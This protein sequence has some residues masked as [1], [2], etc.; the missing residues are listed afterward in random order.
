MAPTA[1]SI[2][3]NPGVGNYNLS[4][5]TGKTSAKFS[6]GKETRSKSARPSTPG[7]GSYQQKNFI[8]KDGPK[9]TISAVRPSTSMG[10]SANLPG[11]GAYITNLNDKITSPTFKF[12]KAKRIKSD[13]NINPGAGAYNPLNVSSSRPKSPTWS[14]GRGMRYNKSITDFVP[15]PGNYDIKNSIGLAPKVY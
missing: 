6:F 12:G 8:G 1:T 3:N 10:N 9:I 5:D 7:P 4:N 11:P 2:R 15:G 13:A 14:M